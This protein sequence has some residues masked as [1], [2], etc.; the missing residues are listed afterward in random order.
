M[1]LELIIPLLTFAVSNI[2]V[3]EDFIARHT[4]A[5]TTPTVDEVKALVASAQAKSDQVNEDWKNS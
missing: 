1:G 4:T 3:V 2:P 5:G